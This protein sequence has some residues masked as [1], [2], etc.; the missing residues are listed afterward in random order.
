MRDFNRRLKRLQVAA[1]ERGSSRK[2][3]REN[4]RHWDSLHLVSAIIDR[5]CANGECVRLQYH[6]ECQHRPDRDPPH[7][8]LEHAELLAAYDAP[9]PTPGWNPR[10]VMPGY[11]GAPSLDPGK[12]DAAVDWD[13]RTNGWPTRTWSWLEVLCA[14]VTTEATR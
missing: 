7:F 14:D 1:A 13:L 8:H 6:H 2:R 9:P 11:T 4:V 3:I 10:Q 5:A 12:L